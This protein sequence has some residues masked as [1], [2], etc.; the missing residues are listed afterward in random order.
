MKL[1]VM[2]DIHL[3][4]K[5]NWLADPYEW[6]RKATQMQM[7]ESEDIIREAFDII[8]ADPDTNTVLITGDLTDNGERNSHEDLL[9]IFEEYTQKGLRILVTTSTHD[10]RELK[11]TKY[12]KVDQNK[13][14][15]YGY[16][17]EYNYKRFL[18]C[19]KR[20]DLRAWYAPYGRKE[21][22]S[23]HE[24]SMSYTYDLDEKY[25]LIAINDDYIA[26]EKNSHRGLDKNQL[27]WILNEAKRATEEDKKIVCFTHH[28]VLTPSPV[29]KLI[30]SHDIIADNINLANLLADNGINVI[31][32]GHSHIHDIE[33][34]K[35]ENGNLIYD[36]ATGALVGSPPLMR[37]VN[38]L[39]DGTIDVKTIIIK[40]LSRFDLNGKSLPE[41]C[42]ESFFGMIE[43]MVGEMS[44]DMINFAIYANSISIRPWTVYQF[45]WIFKAVGIFLNKLTV[46]KVYKW[47]KKECGLSPK[48]INAIKDEKVVPIILEMV[49][50]L[51]AGNADI[52]PDNPKFNI[53]MGTVAIIDDIIATLKINLKKLIGFGTLKEIVEP[54]VYNNGIDDYD[55]VINPLSEPKKNPPLP[56]FHSQKG[57]GFLVTIIL[58]II[59]TFPI[60]IPSAL[61]LT[62]LIALRGVFN[63]YKNYKKVLPP[64][65][66]KKNN[67]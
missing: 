24:E 23:V 59:L 40:E 52:T 58:G 35:S 56:S 63:P 55:A 36:I 33:Y 51:Y 21:A 60:L 28:P 39:D 2:T 34:H 49:E 37:K 18:P 54:L 42:R 38:Y 19:A 13:G 22:L 41:Y 57:V 12:S 26:N 5:R 15:S 8:L 65:V 64:R 20:E 43:D 9:K 16:D 25:R 48:D 67:N 50:K 17:E 1:Y 45:W 14:L 10:Y 4:S 27:S 31:Y 3:Y 7:R 29:Y 44:G 32:T 66:H 6:E 47:C 62:L 53:I 61:I 46:G 11:K 30:G